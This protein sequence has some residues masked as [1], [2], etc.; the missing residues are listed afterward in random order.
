MGGIRMVSDEA[1]GALR[2]IGVA[3]DARRLPRVRNGGLVVL[4]ELAVPL[5]LSTENQNGPE[6]QRG[7]PARPRQRT[8]GW[9]RPSGGPRPPGATAPAVGA[10]LQTQVEEQLSGLQVQYPGTQLWN[11][12]NGIWLLSPSRLLPGLSQFVVFA[13]AIHYVTALVRGW[14]FWSSAVM[15]ATWIG[16]RHTNIPDGSI[17]AFDMAAAEWNWEM[18]LVT[19]LDL[20]S[21]W[22][23]CQLHLNVYGRWPGGQA[24]HFPAERVLELHP[25]E[26][27]GCSEG[28]KVYRDCCMQKDLA[29]N[30]ISDS[31]S[32]YW[33][34]GRFRK[35]PEGVVAF[36]RQRAAPPPLDAIFPSVD[37][38]IAGLSQT[39]ASTTCHGSSRLDTTVD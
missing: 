6:K 31:L 37:E 27:C 5:T 34:G 18:P 26:Y 23:V 4:S 29:R 30:R 15:P 22:S 14:A 24:V 32:F 7:S 20:Y 12:D 28:M 16:P 11:Q 38:W 19:L 9:Q 33:I 17:C 10:G 1:L 2:A 21:V 35:P 25:D 39:E 13:T 36:A 3:L 8:S